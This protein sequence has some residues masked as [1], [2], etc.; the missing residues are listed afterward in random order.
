MTSDYYDD[1][2]RI[3]SNLNH[4]VNSASLQWASFVT[5]QIYLQL[6]SGELLYKNIMV[7]FLEKFQPLFLFFKRHLQIVNNESH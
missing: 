1:V 5:W 3:G 7:V 6:S 4:N 2:E